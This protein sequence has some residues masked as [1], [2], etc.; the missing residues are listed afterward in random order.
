MFATGWCGGMS[1]GWWLLMAGLW[2]G[3]LAVVVWAVLWLFPHGRRDSGGHQPGGQ[4][5]A[6]DLERQLAA[7]EIDVDDYLRQRDSLT[8]AR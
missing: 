3:F 4:D 5:P 6:A 8:G 1:A 7:G 2:A